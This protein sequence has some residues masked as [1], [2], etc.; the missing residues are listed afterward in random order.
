MAAMRAVA[1]LVVV[2][3]AGCAT[4]MAPAPDLRA[5]P[6]YDHAPSDDGFYAFEHAGGSLVFRLTEG[7]EATLDLFG[8]GDSRVG[9]YELRAVSEAAELRLDGVIAGQYVVHVVQHGGRLEI[10]AGGRAPLLQPLF[11]HVERIILA[12]E[13]PGPVPQVPF[14]LEPEDTQELHVALART[15][16]S[17]RLL[18]DGGFSSLHL[19]L[20]GIDGDVVLEAEAYGDPL[21]LL[22]CSLCE[23]PSTFHGA[24]ARDGQLIGT[25]ET[26]DLQGTIVLEA[27]S[28]SRAEPPGQ[29]A[30]GT[31]PR[32]PHFTY[33]RLPG[34]PVAFEVAA[35]AHRLAFWQ[36]V[37]QGWM[38][39][40]VVFDGQDR[41]VATVPVTINDISTL[42][43]TGPGTFVAV[44]VAG[45]NVTMGA[46]AAPQDHA[47]AP[48][49]T[50]FKDIPAE[51]PGKEGAYGQ[52][53]MTVARDRLFD[54]RPVD[55]EA[56]YQPVIA[57]YGDGKVRVQQG[58]ETIGA[59][60]SGDGDSPWFGP[61]PP[62]GVLL[63]DGPVTV[64]SDGSGGGSGCSH[65]G[66]QLLSYER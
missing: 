30:V 6:F 15:P 45:N 23:V 51:P 66:A 63:A 50:H 11:G 49:R 44:V 35:G 42:Q 16:V 13:L 26:R 12:Q 22:G 62:V 38:G 47:L 9:T 48:L 36:D 19:Y 2:T 39:W 7:S 5:S 59:W 53:N 41:K 64:W 56:P 29:A 8:D 32:P 58:G 61:F 4:P 28:F 10:D 3:L 43:V 52:A 27:V 37:K 24:A 34:Q 1:L 65:E 21:P 14:F 17:L 25:L 18:A 60:G 31:Q 46:D 57:C 33:G 55:V 40:V 54:I 20:E